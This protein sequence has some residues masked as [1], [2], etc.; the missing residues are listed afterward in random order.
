MEARSPD[1]NGE[2]DCGC[3]FRV[4]ALVLGL[5]LRGHA[6]LEVDRAVLAGSVAAPHSLGYT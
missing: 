2:G 1:R 5:F 6:K 4:G 3:G